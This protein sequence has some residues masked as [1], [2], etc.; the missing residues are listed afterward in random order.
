MKAKPF[1]YSVLKGIVAGRLSLFLAVLIP[2]TACTTVSP[3]P[4]PKE[5]GAT[6]IQEGV[7]GGVV[8]NTMDVSARV[9]AIDTANRKVTFL[10]PDGNKFAVKVGPEAVNFD[11]IRVGDL[12]NATLTEELV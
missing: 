3:P 12:V 1:S 11:Q 6:A 8:V 4:P 2:I 9:T 5:T 7:P 10:G